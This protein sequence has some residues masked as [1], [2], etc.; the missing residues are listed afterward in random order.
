MNL[1]AWLNAL[2][3]IAGMLWV[4]GLLLMSFTYTVVARSPQGNGALLEGVR[5]WSRNVT[6]PSMIV[7]WVAGIVMVLMYGQFPHAWLLLKIVVVVALSALHGL[8]SGALRRLNSG[9]AARLAW[10]RHAPVMLV[11]AVIAIIVL[12][13]VRPF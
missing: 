12:A 1:H 9:E 13:I 10:L 11:V 7:L 2:H 4:F 3:I 5:R 6:S 8:L